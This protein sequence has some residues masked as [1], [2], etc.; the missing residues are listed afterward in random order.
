MFDKVSHTLYG[1]AG[2]GNFVVGDEK[3]LS[4]IRFIEDTSEISKYTKLKC[5]IS[6][7]TQYIDTG[8]KPNNNTEYEVSGY[9]NPSGVFGVAR[10]SGD[11]TYDTFGAHS[12]TANPLDYYGRYSDNK[13]YNGPSS[14]FNN[15]I[16]WK[17]TKNNI[18]ITNADNG[19]VY[20]NENITTATFQS[21]YNMWIFA[22]NN[23]GSILARSVGCKMYYF[24]IWDNN[25]LIRDYIPVIRNSDNKPGMYDRVTKT[26]FTNQG[27]GEFTYETL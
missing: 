14:V 1:N 6:S 16:V 5:L 23:M 8:F 9:M 18:S 22:F 12:V 25:A 19:T 7:G 10:W 13:Y 27:T 11:S 24:K 20:V 21:T 15:N 2:T 17:H 4:K 26:F 3:I